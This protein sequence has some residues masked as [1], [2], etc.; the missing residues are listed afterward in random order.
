MSQ[1]DKGQ[2]IR[3]LRQEREDEGE[4]EGNRG[5][6]GYLP[7]RDKGLPLK[8]EDRRDPYGNGAVCVRM[9]CF[10]LIGHVN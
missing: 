10:N 7:Q 9:R 3:D 8:R 6:K 2:G 4:G 5:G 1:R